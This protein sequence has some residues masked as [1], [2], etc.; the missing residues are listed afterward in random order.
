MVAA[1]RVIRALDQIGEVRKPHVQQAG[2]VVLKS[3]D[4]PSMLV[5]T[6]YISNAREEQR[7]RTERQQTALADAI[8]GGLRSYFADHPPPGSQLAQVR[9]SRRTSPA[10]FAS[11]RTT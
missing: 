7:L 9:L 1:Q 10:R 2:F 3:P 4:I 5:E 6:A 8:F 11:W